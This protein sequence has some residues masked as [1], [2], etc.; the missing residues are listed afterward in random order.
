M[1]HRAAR[2]PLNSI[3]GFAELL[4]LELADPT[5]QEYAGII[6]QS[7]EHLLNLVNEIL[8]LAKIESGEMTVKAIPT[9]IAELVTECA[10]GHQVAAG[11]NCALPCTWPPTCRNSFTPTP[12]ACARY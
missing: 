5:H 7:S 10:A 1:S 11:N 2:T 6:R 8:D 3:L 12:C 9:P 4:K